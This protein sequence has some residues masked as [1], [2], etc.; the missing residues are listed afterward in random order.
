MMQS[1]ALHRTQTPP[2]AAQARPGTWAACAPE[3]REPGLAGT[4]IGKANRA[5]GAFGVDRMAIH[6]DG[7]IGRD[8]RYENDQRGRAVACA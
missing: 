2:A 7:F 3:P 4:A 1:L 5:E 8:R 6:R